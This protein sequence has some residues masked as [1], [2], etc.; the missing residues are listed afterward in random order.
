MNSFESKREVTGI[1]LFFCA[2]ALILLYYLPSEV[3]GVLGNLLKTIGGGFIGAAAFT[4]PIF[5]LYAAIDFFLEKRAGV[6]PIRIRSVIIFLICL[7]A[8]LSVITTDFD[9]FRSL[10]ASDVDQKFKATEAI[11]LLWNSGSDSTLITPVGGSKAIPGGILGGLLATSLHMV[12]GKIAS[13]VVL[14]GRIAS[15]VIL[16]FHISLKT[17]VK[18]TAKAVS[19]AVR[20]NNA[21]RTAQRPP[22]RPRP[23]ARPQ[24]KVS[25]YP[26]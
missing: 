6:S 26:T 22:Q 21:R 11:S 23:Q 18:K 16:V 5:I 19:T 4:I 2:I 17:T 7:S 15:Q 8:L 1:V 13:I 14:I 24:P 10:C 9:Y 20:N 25:S 12:C 3:T